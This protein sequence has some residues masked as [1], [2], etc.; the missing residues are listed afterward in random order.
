LNKFGFSP[1]GI[2]MI[3]PYDARRKR[4]R[5][6]LYQKTSLSFLSVRRVILDAYKK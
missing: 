5:G 4:A 1:G 2:A 3:I 6:A